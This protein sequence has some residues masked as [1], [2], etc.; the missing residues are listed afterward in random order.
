MTEAPTQPKWR[1]LPEE[2]PQQILDAAFAVFG[3]HGLSAA[4]L[5][6]I[7]QRAGVSKGTI[8]LYF[9]NKEA[10]FQ[11]MIRHTIVA[12]IEQWERDDV[13]A[14][15]TATEQLRAYMADWWGFLR[16]EPFQTIYRLVQ[17]EL[18]RFPDLARFYAEEVVARAHGLIAGIVQRG[19][20]NGE[21]RGTDSAAAARMAAALFM[22]YSAWC[23]KQQLFR[24]VGPLN[25]REALEQAIDFILHALRPDR[26]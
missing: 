7:A 4:R 17:S 20:E 10:L 18:H 19:I 12:R 2:R 25:D 3:E 24:I 11:E 1:R 9:P 26:P 22:S 21:F 13:V 8:Y 6:D 15:G 14:R 16:S 5:E 23:A